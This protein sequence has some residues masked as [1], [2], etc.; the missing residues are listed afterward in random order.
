MA[1]KKEKEIDVLRLPECSKTELVQLAHRIGLP[2]INKGMLEDD[3]VS[4][5]LGEE[6]AIN[7]GI[8]DVRGRVY[9]YVKAH[10]TSLLTTK[11]DCD[12]YCPNCPQDKMISCFTVN[13]DLIENY[14]RKRSE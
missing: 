7:D 12:A 6:V 9:N 14:E 2:S 5:I 13:E 10:Q 4:A 3:I 8:E 11:M 1:R